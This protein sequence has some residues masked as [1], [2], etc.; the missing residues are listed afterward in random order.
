[1]SEIN[2][3]S[4]TEFLADEIVEH[5]GGWHGK[6]ELKDDITESMDNNSARNFANGIIVVTVEGT[7]YTILVKETTEEP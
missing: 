4:I 7:S 3:Q 6:P 1:M 2:K 5:L